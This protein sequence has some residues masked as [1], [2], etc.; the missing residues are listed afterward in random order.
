MTCLVAVGDTEATGQLTV[1]ISTD[2][3][4]TEVPSPETGTF[5]VILASV[6]EEVTVGAPVIELDSGD[7]ASKAHANAPAGTTLL[8]EA[9]STPSAASGVAVATQSATT[10]VSGRLP[11]TNPSSG[12]LKLSAWVKRMM[13]DNGVNALSLVDTGPGGRITTGDVHA[14]I[15]I[16]GSHAEAPSNATR[17]A[18]TGTT[19]AG[20][21]ATVA[22]RTPVKRIEPLSRTRRI[23]SKRVF[24][25]LQT[26]AQSTAAVEADVS[27]IIAIRTQVQDLTRQRHGVSLSPLSFVAFATAR[28]LA[29]HPVLNASVDGKTGEVTYH[30]KAGLGVAIDAPQGLVVTVVRDAQRL[31]PILLKQ[32]IADFAARSRDN[33][34]TPDDLRGGT[35]TITD[36]GSRGSLFDTLILNAPEIGILATPAFEKRPVIST[37]GNVGDR[38]A[39]RH[40]TEPCLTYDHRFVDK[41]DAAR[42]LG[43]LAT[44]LDSIDLGAEMSDLVALSDG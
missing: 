21:T 3:V 24:R 16:S 4:D 43:N 22:C 15:V 40:R 19:S 44:R 25:S 7:M 34:L 2:K 31:D 1:K 32:Q 27:R 12:E 26:T 11:P 9:K 39:I 20:A 38:I 37:D 33:N 36:T 10:V 6:D 23:I 8:T 35:F 28:A 18:A 30:D 13:R 14:A 42:F 41:A 17:P 5:V 29:D